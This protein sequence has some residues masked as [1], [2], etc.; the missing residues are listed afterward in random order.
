MMDKA[1]LA[2]GVCAN[3]GPFK[4]AIDFFSL[5]SEAGEDQSICTTTEE[6]RRT[7]SCMAL[8]DRRQFSLPKNVS[9]QSANPRRNRKISSVHYRSRTYL[10]GMAVLAVWTKLVSRCISLRTG[11]LTANSPFPGM[12]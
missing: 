5:S 11:K 7:I 9:Q 2:D 4:G 10:C 3:P 6:Y 8:F 12:F 1:A